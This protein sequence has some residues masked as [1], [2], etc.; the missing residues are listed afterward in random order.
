[1]LPIILQFLVGSES[2]VILIGDTKF[3]SIVPSIFSNF[4]TTKSGELR[5]VVS[6]LYSLW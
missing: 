4:K 5:A 6:D 3:S 1:M 2:L